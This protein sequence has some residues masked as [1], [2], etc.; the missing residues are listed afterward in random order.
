MQ[1]AIPMFALILLVP[2][3]VLAQQTNEL[4]TKEIDNPHI[5]SPSDSIGP[6][7]RADD[8]NAA[9]SKL[10]NIMQQQSFGNFN[11]PDYPFILTAVDE[12]KG[13]LVVVMHAMAATANIEYEEEEIAIALNTDVPIDIQYGVFVLE[14]SQSRIESWKQYYKDNCIPVKAGY[15]TVCKI[16]GDNLRKEGINPDSLGSTPTVT[17]KPT[18]STSP[19]DEDDD[20][21]ACYY[22]KRYQDKCIPTKTTSRCDTYATQI[23]NAGYEVPTT[24]PTIVKVT[25]PKV[26][27]LQATLSGDDIKVTWNTPQYAV[28]KYRVH[29]YED[30]TRVDREYVYVNSYTYDEVKKGK[31][32]K[33]RVYVYYESNAKLTSIYGGYIW[34]NVVSVPA[35]TTTI[36]PE[37][38]PN[39]TPTPAVETN[40]TTIY[41]GNPYYLKAQNSTHVDDKLSTVTIGATNSTGSVGVVVS[42][43]GIILP[44][45]FTFTGHVFGANS[46][47]FS[48]SM[49]LVHFGPQIDA[50]FIPITEPNIVVENKVQS[51][52]GDVISVVNGTLSSVPPHETLSIYGSQ[53]NGNG[54]LLYKNATTLDTTY[55]LNNVGIALYPSTNGDSGAPITY[56]NSGTVHIVGVHQGGVCIFQPVSTPNLKVDVSK[57]PSYCTPGATHFK[58]FSAWEL[59]RETLSLQ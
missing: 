55:V 34:S 9:H 56:N 49:V 46:T 58:V 31:D 26:T 12:Q 50:A 45:G 17:P 15:Q 42:G 24:K 51:L 59:V 19:C 29:I 47:L 39:P 54:T 10:T 2:A 36:T 25:P 8:L 52:T 33:F 5:L 30:N 40:S 53:T 57:Y 37:S 7:G 4:N 43:H 6:V 48:N 23:K 35:G 27:G 21:L 44:S 32:Y 3:G 41:G 13:D 11:T 1:L 18:K 20:S 16:F 28:D 22:Y 38:N 14:V